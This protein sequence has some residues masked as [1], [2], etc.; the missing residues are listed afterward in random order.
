MWIPVIVFA[1]LSGCNQHQRKKPDPTKG[2]VTGIVLCADTGKPARFAT[3]TLTGAPQQ[4]QKNDQGDPLPA[5]ESTVTDL[6]GRFTMEAVEPGRYWAFATQEGY[7]DPLRGLDLARIEAL[8]TDREQSLD[9]VDQWK[10]HLVDVTVHA[11]R[12]VEIPISMERGAEI[13]GTVSFDD[14]SPAIGM[15]FELQRKTEKSWTNV[16]ITLFGEWSIDA[17]S[18]SR[19]RFSLTNLAAGEYR[20]CAVMPEDSQKNSQRVCLGDTLRSKDSKTVKVAAGEDATG[21]EIVI[22]LSGLHKLGGTVTSVADGHALPTGTVHL[23]YADDREEARESNLANDGTFLFEYVAEGKYI[24]QV[25]GAADAGDAAPGVR[26]P[27]YSTREIPVSVLNDTEDLGLSL[28]QIQEP[29]AS[30]PTGTSGPN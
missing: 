13:S 14:G 15:H 2:T 3:V 1:A 6:E 16:G 22:P 29:A 5:T 20:I 19:G 21:L 17:K 11:H 25:T 8:R 27:H 24:L 12:A 23:L 4:D 9:A 26:I 7:L 10:T 18:D 30:S 28:S